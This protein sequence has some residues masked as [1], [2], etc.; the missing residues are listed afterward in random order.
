[1]F[2][3]LV[4]INKFL[5]LFNQVNTYNTDPNNLDTVKGYCKQLDFTVADII[6]LIAGMGLGKTYVVNESIK[7]NK[8]KRI[9]LISPRQTFCQEKVADLQNICPDFRSY[10]DEDVR[11]I[12]DWSMVNKLAIQVES[13][14]KLISIDESNKYD[15]LILD[16]IESILYQF[17]SET[18]TEPFRCFQVFMELLASSG[19]IV[20]ADAFITNRTMSLCTNVLIKQHKRH[21]NVEI[22][23]HNPNGNINA[24]IIG[25]ARNTDALIVLKNTF[26]NH[27]IENL[28]ANKKICVVVSSKDFKD[29]IVDLAIKLLGYQHGVNVLS[30]DRD[31]SDEDINNLAQVKYVWGRD[32]VRLVIYTTKITVGINFDV[33][34]KFDNIY[35]YGSVQCP[36]ARDLLQSH[37]R[38]RNIIDKN[39][40]VALNCCYIPEALPKD[41]CN[42]QFATFFI[43]NIKNRFGF[44]E[45]YQ[46]ST[47][48]GNYVNI[49][50]Y[51]FLEEI[52]GHALYADVFKYFLKATGYNI[53][54]DYDCDIALHTKH[55]CSDSLIPSTYIKRYIEYRGMSTEQINDIQ[56]RSR[57][58]RATSQDKET[59]TSYFF[60]RKYIY[61]KVDLTDDKVKAYLLERDEKYYLLLNNRA[62]ALELT[63]P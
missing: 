48:M 52:I 55:A 51:N 5:Y 4:D 54:L 37:F 23:A 41:K 61:G 22:N 30:Y 56:I 59:L 39:I 19:K 20:M 29:H 6:I 33:M 7:A 11:R 38:V 32:A 43:S 27:L 31:T 58:Q 13:L 28:K 3:D 21:V 63:I 42:I 47:V 9:L 62:E 15:L 40:Y 34:D 25:I 14:H 8:F 24:N 26:T 44:N 18:N 60:A 49:A 1:M 50:Q 57:L 36:I 10:L 2:D 16:E 12:C 53:V 35:I 17:S 46:D 45:L